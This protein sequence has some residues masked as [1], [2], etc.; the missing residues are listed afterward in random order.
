MAAMVDTVQRGTATRIASTLSGT[1]W[2]IG[3]KTG[4]GGRAGGPLNQQDGWFAGLIF[5]N[6]G[7]ARYT[8]ATFV[9][10]GGLGGGNAAEISAQLARFLTVG[11]TAE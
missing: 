5:D 11:R 6:Q 3:G 1:G 7:K 2:A 9:R 4:T 8:V 10:R